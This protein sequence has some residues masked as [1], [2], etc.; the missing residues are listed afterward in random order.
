MR[1]IA[2]I[3]S[4]HNGSLERALAL[5]EA[6]ARAGFTDVKTQSFRVREMFAPEA[7]EA[8]PELRLREKLEVPWSWHPQLRQ[9]VHALGMRYGITVCHRDD[10]DELSRC[11]DWLKVGSYSLLDVFLLKALSQAG[12]PLVVSTGMATEKEVNDALYHLIVP[13]AHLPVR[14]LQLTLLH[15]V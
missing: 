8:R 1:W 7:L 9:R 4:N 2:E 6:A 13:F 10:V 12:K 3:G 15:C 11:A 14:P 5:V